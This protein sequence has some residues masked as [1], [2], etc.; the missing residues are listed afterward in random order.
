MAQETKTCK[1]CG[2]EIPANAK[3]CK[4]CGA[5]QRNWFRRHWFITGFFG[6]I[7]LIAI[8]SA[9]NK[10][11]SQTDIGGINAEKNK[12]YVE[13]SCKDFAEKFGLS[14][15]LTNLQKDT[16][17]DQE[18]KNKYVK[19]NGEI[20]FVQEIWGTLSVQ[21]KCNPK[22]FTSDTI[23][24]FDQSQKNKLVNYKEG[25]TIK[26]EARLDSWGQLMPS[27]LKEG[28]VTE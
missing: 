28:V 10:S 17:F 13:I 23:I 16:I 25:D 3:K 18:Y 21:V 9:G 15:D 1:S 22:S 7:I 11:G 5:D 12:E 20:T 4:H 19:W 27:S 24:S 14:N 6:L 2:G 26:F 8:G